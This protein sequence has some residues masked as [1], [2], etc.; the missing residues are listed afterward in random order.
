MRGKKPIEITIRIELGMFQKIGEA[1]YR[2]L[3]A[4]GI[5]IDLSTAV[6]VAT[7]LINQLVKKGKTRA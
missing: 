5:S 3:R 4:R 1:L 6:E 7:G 2:A